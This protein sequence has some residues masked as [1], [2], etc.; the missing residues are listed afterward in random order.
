MKKVDECEIP[1]EWESEARLAS[2]SSVLFRCF[3]PTRAFILFC[4]AFCAFNR[5]RPSPEHPKASLWLSIPEN[6]TF[7]P[8]NQLFATQRCEGI[9]RFLTR[10]RETQSAC[11]EAFPCLQVLQAR[12]PNCQKNKWVP[13][14]STQAQCQ[15]SAG[16]AFHGTE[17]NKRSV[18]GRATGASAKVGNP[19]YTTGPRQVLGYILGQSNTPR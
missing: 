7:R 4:L 17:L 5:C 18:K 13:V 10:G 16:D 8:G 15:K 1:S 2:P 12:W 11:L 6:Y 9:P 19:S 14:P 3:C